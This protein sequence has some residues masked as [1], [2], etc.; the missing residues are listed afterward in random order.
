MRRSGA[1]TEFNRAYKRRRMEATMS[2][3]GFMTYTCAEARLRPAL[4]PLLVNRQMIG[5][6]QSLFAGIF[7]AT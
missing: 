6:V 5:P 3:C 1:L 7:G 2:G 4:I